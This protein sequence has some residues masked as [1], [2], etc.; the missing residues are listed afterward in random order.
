MN[1]QL[2]D[3]YNNYDKLPTSTAGNKIYQ[4]KSVTY[5][6]KKIDICFDA[7]A[8]KNSKIYTFHVG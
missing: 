4:T 1:Y 2:S 5:L 8:I 7:I 6:I 3:I